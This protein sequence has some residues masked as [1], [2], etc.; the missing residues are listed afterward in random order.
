M[1]KFALT[2]GTFIVGLLAAVLVSS[3]LS[4]GIS[5]QLAIGPQ[6]SKGEKGDSGPA[7]EQ[8]PQG[9]AGAMGPQGPT[10]ATGAQGVQ[11]MTG[12]QGPTGPQGASGTSGPTGAIGPQGSPGPTGPTGLTGPIGP[13]GPY[14]PDYDSGW[15]NITDKAGQFFTVTHNL[16]T[17]DILVDL[18]GKT[19][20]DGGAH[21]RNDGGERGLAWTD[22]TANTLTLYRGLNDVYWNYVRVRVWKI[23]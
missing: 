10:G 14:L 2:K 17:A 16:N 20:A 22:S 19:A 7:G 15:L 5:T 8:G 18:T 4:A 11:G 23:D 12:A 13:Q 1:Q 3:T 6:G 21:Q 9:E